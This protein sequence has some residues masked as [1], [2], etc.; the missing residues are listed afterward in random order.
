MEFTVD[1]FRDEVRCGFYIP[2]AVKQAWAANLTVLNEIDRICEKHGIRYFA[3]W[4]SILGAVRHGGY[5]P[6]DDDL[7]ICMLRDD[8]VRFREVAPAEL[9]ERFEIQDYASKEDH[10]LMLSRVVS[11]HSI[12]FDEEHLAK[13][14]NFPYISVVDIFVQDYLYKDTELERERCREVKE[15]LAVADGT[16]E[17][18]I[19]PEVVA[20]KAEEYE[21]KYGV[22][23][24][25][26]KSY[27]KLAS[28]VL[29]ANGK[30]DCSEEV[31]SFAIELYKHAERQMSRVPAEE[32]DTVVQIF[33]WILKGGQGKPKR[34]YEKSVR[35]PFENTTIP[36]PACYHEI[37][38]SK[39]GDYLV[40]RKVWSGHNYPYFEGQKRNLQSVADFELPEFKFSEEMVAERTG[41]LEEETFK[42]IV[43]AYLEN[44]REYTNQTLAYFGTFDFDKVLE[45]LPE[46]QQMAV[47]LGNFVEKVKGEYTP[48]AVSSVEV[49]Q[50]YC[51]AVYGLNTD[52]YG[53]LDEEQVT[54]PISFTA[55]DRLANIIDKLCDR[56]D[57]QLLKRR[58]V[59]FCPVGAKQWKGF[60]QAYK[61]E[62]EKGDTD[63]YIVPLP[64]LFKDIY[65]RV[66]ASEDEIRS[67]A[68]R[69]AYPEGLITYPWERFDAYTL[70]PDTIYIQD[71]YDGENP[72]LT[73]PSGYYS[74]K[75]KMCTDELI[76]IPAFE[77]GEFSKED[78]NDIY[79]MKHYAT[80]PGVICADRVLLQSENI[81][82]RY[83]DKLAD[84]AGE[85]TRVLWERKLEAA[86]WLYGKGTETVVNDAVKGKKKLL[87]VIGLN[88]LSEHK[89]DIA[90]KVK[91]R[92]E[93]FRENGEGIEVTVKFFPED[94]S[95][96]DKV[97]SKLTNEVDRLIKTYGLKAAIGA[98]ASPEEISVYDAYYGSA[99]PYVPLFVEKKKPVMI[100]DYNL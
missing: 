87:Y 34:Y 20:L 30:P 27:K 53:M 52:I 83:I 55:A 26:L 63:I 49:L 1:Y 29:K 76:F 67:S 84:F 89:Q 99:S 78:I 92:L 10:W 91:Y 86:E 7:D 74:S 71:P 3:D 80:A 59:L 85:K 13:Y 72:C 38:S 17:G 66:T 95:L 82:Q 25:R 41:P 62:S 88:E 16:V 79:N 39:Y 14:H 60:E 96:W 23:L 6:W 54:D 94:K 42:G 93:T 24:P 75:L 58:S 48:S 70:R 50:E 40:A 35:L 12:S 100:A 37:L 19:S 57:E 46:L 4:G 64:V 61:R 28:P 33:P 90:E 73:V 5:V 36:V 44:I 18:S 22:H 9:P 77:T 2:T 98:H 51:D 69:E 15:L 56:L 21:K 8:Y 68:G 31:R 32:A 45:M 97:D 81:R 11:E 65:G 47:D 43:G